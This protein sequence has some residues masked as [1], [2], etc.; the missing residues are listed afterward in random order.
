MELTISAFPLLGKSSDPKVIVVTS[1]VGSITMSANGAVPMGVPGWPYAASKSAINMMLAQWVQ[2]QKNMKFWAVC[3]GLVA[4][5]FGGDFTKNYG[6][7]AKEAADI[8]RQ[9]VEG[10]RESGIG[11]VSWEQEQLGGTGIHPW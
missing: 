11:K 4:T 9:C 2:S 5:E 1:S 7:P 6:R 3:P 8:V 10:E